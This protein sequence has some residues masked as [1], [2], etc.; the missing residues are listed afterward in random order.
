MLIGKKLYLLG[1]PSAD[2]TT[3]V[4]RQWAGVD[5]FIMIG[6]SSGGFLT[7]EYVL[8]Y[9]RHI[10]AI[11][12]GDAAAQMSHWAMGNMIA[13]A[14]TDPRS[15]AAV[16]ANPAQVVRVLTGTCTSQEDFFGAFGAIAPL[17]SAPAELKTRA[18]ID[19]DTVLASATKVVFETNS[20]A[21]NDCLSRYDI[22]DRLGE[23]KVP[24]FIFVGRYDWI[25]PPVLSEELARGI[26]GSKLVVFEQSGHLPPLEE[27][28]KFQREVRAWM[29]ENQL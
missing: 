20:A 22:R 16:A 14:L 8:A 24:A 26:K 3:S 17:Y 15:A 27:K 9:P 25:A 6:G 21:M 1:F 4:H 13:T 18:E 2:K 12:V 7:L 28:T 19:V 23:I 10:S 11:V 5:K 29:D